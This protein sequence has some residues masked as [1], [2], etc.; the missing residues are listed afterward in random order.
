MENEWNSKKVI[1]DISTRMASGIQLGGFRAY[2]ITDIQSS[3]YCIVQKQSTPY[4][5]HNDNKEKKLK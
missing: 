5:I 1:T 3:G 4:T 2:V